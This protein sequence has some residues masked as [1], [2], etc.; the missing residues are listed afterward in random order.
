MDKNFER[1]KNTCEEFQDNIDS[2]IEQ[3]DINMVRM[4]LYELKE[5]AT[6]LYG[7]VSDTE[8]AEK[9]VEQRRYGSTGGC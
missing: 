1:L 3:K 6:K 9:I 7:Q 2:W 8:L 4:C 5:R